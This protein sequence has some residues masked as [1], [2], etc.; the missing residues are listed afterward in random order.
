LF[1]KEIKEVWF[2]GN[3][4]SLLVHVQKNSGIQESRQKEVKKNKKVKVVSPVFF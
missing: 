3:T 1:K 2:N 4:C